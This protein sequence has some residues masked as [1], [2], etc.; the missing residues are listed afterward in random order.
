MA[1]F[2][3]T[4][5]NLMDQRGT[6]ARSLGRAVGVPHKTISDWIAQ[7]VAMPRNPDHLKSISDHFGCSIH[8]LLFGDEEPLSIAGDHVER[9]EL[10]SGTYEVTVRKVSQKKRGR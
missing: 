1:A 4:L 10:F 9:M 7:S 6:S 5:K 3:K 8:F 2:G